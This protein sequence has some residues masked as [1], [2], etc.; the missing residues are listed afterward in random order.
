MTKSRDYWLQHIPELNA[1]MDTKLKDFLEIVK[2]HYAA[3][4]IHVMD[5]QEADLDASERVAISTLALTEF[6][7][8]GRVESVAGNRITTIGSLDGRPVLFFEDMRAYAWSVSD[9][10]PRVIDLNL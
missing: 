6:F 8:N 7:V 4:M 2:P 9:D 1:L 10:A 5:R 3:Q